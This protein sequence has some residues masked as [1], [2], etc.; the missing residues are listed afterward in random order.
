MNRHTLINV[1][2]LKRK[3]SLVT[4]ALLLT[5]DSVPTLKALLP[6]DT[7]RVIPVYTVSLRQA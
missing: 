6:P 1:C 4:E 5:A 2:F 3:K 7:F